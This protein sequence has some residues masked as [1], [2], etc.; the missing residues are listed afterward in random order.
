MDIRPYRIKLHQKGQVDILL[1]TREAVLVVR[2]ASAFADSARRSAVHISKLCQRVAVSS[3]FV[4]AIH[5]I[6]C[7]FDGRNNAAWH[8]ERM[9]SLPPFHGGEPN[10]ASV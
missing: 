1:Y 3:R 9:A 7:I 10:V 6:H 4:L 5:A 8:Q 2:V